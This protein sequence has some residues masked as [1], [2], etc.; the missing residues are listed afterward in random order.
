MAACRG[1]LCGGNVMM[2]SLSKEPA[3]STH[4]AM[5]IGAVLV[6]CLVLLTYGGVVV[7][8]SPYMALA[9]CLFYGLFQIV[10]SIAE[11]EEEEEYGH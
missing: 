8:E 7:P 3:M 1:E 6:P 11:E 9:G 10:R 4:T 2:T 5:M